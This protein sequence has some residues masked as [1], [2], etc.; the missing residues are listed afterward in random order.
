MSVKN[1]LLHEALDNILTVKKVMVTKNRIVAAID[2]GTAKVAAIA[3]VKDEFGKITVLGCGEAESKGVVRG[4]VQN[5][6]EVASAIKAAVM[7]CKSV[8]GVDFKDVFVGIAGQN[9]RCTINSHS[10]YINSGIVTQDDIDRITN[11]VYS[12][13]KEPGEEIIHVIPQGYTI[14]DSY[15]GLNPVGCPAKKLSGDFYVAVGSAGSLSAIRRA[16]GLA[17]LNIVKI[18]LTSVASGEAVLTV[19]EKEAGV[20]VADIGGGTTDIAVYQNRVLKTTSYVPFGGIAVTNDI[21]TA[22]HIIARQAELLKTE[23]GSAFKMSGDKHKIAVVNSFGTD[24]EISFSDLAE[25]IIARMDEILGSIACVVD[26]Y[27]LKEKLAAGIVITGGGAKLK[28]IAQLV[29]FRLGMDV[30]FAQPRYNEAGD[31]RFSATVGLLLKGFEY[32]ETYEK[33]RSNSVSQNGTST[34][35]EQKN[36]SQN[37]GK[38]A[39]EKK[40]G[41]TGKKEKEGGFLSKF[42]AKVKNAAKDFLEDPDDTKI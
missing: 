18:I 15:V 19:D 26:K 11:E 30:R 7:K 41:K 12:I 36:G 17:G 33:I 2:I 34:G 21:S 25:I 31:A 24:K 9:V 3:G 39:E 8:S 37:T 5:V 13:N 10:K 28:D 16:V 6:S 23:Y 38:P 14:D 27:G 35:G 29:K 20:L 42:I 4:S 40:D 22:C 1:E 32:L